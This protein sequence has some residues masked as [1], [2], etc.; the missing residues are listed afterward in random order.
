VNQLN[1]CE[2]KKVDDDDDDTA[3]TRV[4]AL[5]AIPNILFNN[6]NRDRQNTA[7]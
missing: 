4:L 7:H 1:F 3:G 5:N 6:K 2:V